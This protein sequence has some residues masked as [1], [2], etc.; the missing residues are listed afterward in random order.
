MPSSSC[1]NC[2]TCSGGTA[3]NGVTV[4]AHLLNSDTLHVVTSSRTNVRKIQLLCRVNDSNQSFQQLQDNGLAPTPV[5]FSAPLCLTPLSQTISGFS[6]GAFRRTRSIPVHPPSIEI[7]TRK[8]QSSK[9]TRTTQ[10]TANAQRDDYLWSI[11]KLWINHL[12]MLC[13]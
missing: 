11:L 4:F 12:S 2:A 6:N 1:S 3:T 8:P 13:K 5:S 10:M 9:F 7:W